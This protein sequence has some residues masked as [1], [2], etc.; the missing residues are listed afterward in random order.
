MTENKKLTIPTL[1]D[2]FF[3]ALKNKQPGI[4]IDNLIKAMAK[5]E[6]GTPCHIIS[7]LNCLF[8]LAQHLD[9][10]EMDREHHKKLFKKL[11]K[12]IAKFEQDGLSKSLLKSYLAFSSELLF[13]LTRFEDDFVIE[14]GAEKELLISTNYDFLK[15]VNGLDYCGI[16]PLGQTS[17]NQQPAPDND[18]LF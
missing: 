16:L 3:Q 7:K 15:L 13:N 5:R 11:V 18:I 8:E 17:S 14:L 9:S 10:W 1:E 6:S 4:N 12:K 2:L